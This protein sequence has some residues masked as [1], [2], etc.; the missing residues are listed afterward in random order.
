MQLKTSCQVMLNVPE[1]G[2]FY[3]LIKVIPVR[4]MGTFFN[5]D[6]GSLHRSQ[7]SEVR[8]PLLG[9]NDLN[10]VFV[11]V[12]MRTHWD[13]RRYPAAFCYGGCHENGQIAVSRKL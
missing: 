6:F 7:A 4:R 8:Q 9:N 13:D 2:I 11:V 5:D 3:V 10:R 12:Y 1:S